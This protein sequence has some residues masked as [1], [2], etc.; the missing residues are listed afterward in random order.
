MISI[1]EI[2]ETS[3]LVMVKKWLDAHFLEGFTWK[4]SPKAA[5]GDLEELVEKRFSA[6]SARWRPP[7][8]TNRHGSPPWL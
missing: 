1:I 2:H 7:S 3:G 6:P 8:P 4:M 5:E